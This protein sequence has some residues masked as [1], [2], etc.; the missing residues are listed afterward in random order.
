MFTYQQVLAQVFNDLKLVYKNFLHWNL[1]KIVLFAYV[2]LASLIL[3]IPFLVVMFYGIYL[4]APSVQSIP[5]NES[6]QMAGILLSHI[7]L[8]LMILFCGLVILSIIVFFFAYYYYLLSRVYQ[9]YFD[10]ERLGYFSNHYFSW[11]HIWK[12][13]GMISWVGL[14]LLLPVL[15][16]GV[17]FLILGALSLWFGGNSISNVILGSIGLVGILS[18]VFMFIYLGI[19]LA[20][21]NYAL[22]ET[23]D[24]D[25]ATK[26][27]IDMSFALTKNKFWRVAGIL[28]P[29]MIGLIIINQIVVNIQKTSGDITSIFLGIVSFLLLDGI[30]YMVY[31]SLYRILKNQK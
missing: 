14:Y 5:V 4:L 28:A 7:P 10:E 22:I 20:F 17:L 9:G 25:Q 29:Y 24:I 1:S 21:A 6:A 19:R 30:I 31:Y 23:S 11:K 15:G 12:Y 8:V 27:Y 16:F 18:G 26:N 3:S 2:I 13:L